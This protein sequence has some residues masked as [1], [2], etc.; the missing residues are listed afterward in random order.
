MRRFLLRL[1]WLAIFL[2]V[3]V[4]TAALAAEWAE[5][6]TVRAVF[7]GQL[8]LGGL[9][10]IG[11]QTVP[12][13]GRGASSRASKRTGRGWKRRAAMGTRGPRLRVYWRGWP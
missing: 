4:Q 7:E 10:R 9:T 1:A 2:C 11:L 5:P 3:P 6:I 8:P 12:A 13:T